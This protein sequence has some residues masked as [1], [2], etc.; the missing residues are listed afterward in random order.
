MKMDRGVAAA[1]ICSS[2][3]NQQKSL[4]FQQ[5]LAEPMVEEGAAAATRKTKPAGAALLPDPTEP[6]L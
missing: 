2:T 3:D 6:E 1:C 5:F 4:S